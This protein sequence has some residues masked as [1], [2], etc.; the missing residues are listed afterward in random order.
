[1]ARNGG[2]L[3]SMQV[4]V[5]KTHKSLLREVLIHQAAEEEEI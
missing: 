1:M 5:Q 2:T 4:S 3:D